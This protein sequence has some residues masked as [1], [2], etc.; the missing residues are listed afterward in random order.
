[1]KR[2]Y[3]SIIIFKIIVYIVSGAVVAQLLGCCVT[4]LKIRG[5]SP[6]NTKLLLLLGP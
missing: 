5:S 4:D 6:I 3:H 2:E 1:M